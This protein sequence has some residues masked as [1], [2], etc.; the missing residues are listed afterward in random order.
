MTFSSA[1]FFVP[2]L[3][4]PLFSLAYLALKASGA[5]DWYS[6]LGLSLTLKPPPI[7]ILIG[8]CIIVTLALLAAWPAIWRLNRK[9]PRDLLAAMRG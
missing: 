5:K 7:P 3:D 8:W 2:Y 9:R 4:S 6:G 1:R